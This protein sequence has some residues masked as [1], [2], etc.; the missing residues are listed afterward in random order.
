M[1]LGYVSKQASA[2]TKTGCLVFLEIQ[3]GQIPMKLKKFVPDLGV[4]A[5]TSLRLV[6]GIQFSGQSIIERVQAQNEGNMRSLI[7]ADSWFGSVKMVEAMKCL[8]Q[9]PR[10]PT[11]RDRRSYFVAVDKELG[12]NNNAPEVIC[13]IKT[14]TGWFPQEEL[15]KEMEGYPSGAYL[16]LECKAPGTNVDLVAIGYKY[17]SR[18]T[19]TFAMSKNAET[20]E[21]GYPYIARFADE[22]GNVR[23]RRVLRPKCLSVYFG[24]S[25][26]I[27]VHNHFRQGILR[28]EMLWKTPNPWFRLVSTII[29]VTVVDCHTAVKFHLGRQFA[30]SCGIEQFADCLAWDLTHNKFNKQIDPHATIRPNIV[31]NF[32]GRG[33]DGTGTN[34]SIAEYVRMMHNAFMAQ[35]GSGGVPAGIMNPPFP[36]TSPAESSLTS[37]SSSIAADDTSVSTAGGAFSLWCLPTS[38]SSGSSSSQH[39]T[40]DHRPIYNPD[41][42][43][44]SDGKQRPKGRRCVIC[45]FQ[46]R[47]ICGHPSCMSQTSMRKVQGSEEMKESCG[48]PICRAHIIRPK[49]KHPCIQEH[50]IRLEK[51]RARQQNAE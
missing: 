10:Q 32:M 34:D 13:A 4:T 48:V 8:H 41:R 36:V 27:D 19:L 14:N 24:V 37:S 28:L 40:A 30:G 45:G 25:N 43:T 31:P 2:D 42:T 47:S 5:G 22:H 18:K 9:K 50:I 15:Q 46:T 11:A 49:F 39:P 3:E 7:C 26:I 23:E 17:N 51:E 29:G 38:Q 35:L 1:F 33:G 20:T 44:D 12:Q 21:P 6:E 16:V